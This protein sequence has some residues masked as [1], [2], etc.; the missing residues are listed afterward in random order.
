M[1]QVT[2]MFDRRSVFKTTARPNT[3]TLKIEAGQAKVPS[4]LVQ[5]SGEISKTQYRHNKLCIG[6]Q[7]NFHWS[8]NI[9]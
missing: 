1:L 6:V 2:Q 9:C 3:E 8:T 5:M 4:E 7:Q